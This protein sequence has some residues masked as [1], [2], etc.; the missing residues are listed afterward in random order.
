MYVFRT[1][2]TILVALVATYVS[3]AFLNN[4]TDYSTNL[5]YIR[6]VMTMDSVP[7]DSRHLWRSVQMPL[8]H[9]TAYLLIIILQL[10]SS[11]LCWKGFLK[12]LKINN[13]K[14][15]LCGK[16]TSTIGLIMTFGIWFGGFFVIGGE[17]FLAWQT[18][19]GALASASRV[20]SI[21]GIVL[22]FINLPEDY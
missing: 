7:G 12:M 13:S 22:I 17:W 18:Q 15:F 20:L 11:V 3:M 16:Q 9:H 21:I 4:I 19:W 14:Y 8:L 6:H 1:C 10:L 2:K 5:S